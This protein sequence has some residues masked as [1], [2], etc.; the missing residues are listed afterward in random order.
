LPDAQC[1]AARFRFLPFSPAAFQG[2]E[3][4]TEAALAAVSYDD[5]APMAGGVGR[6]ETD[7]ADPGSLRLLTELRLKL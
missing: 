4:Q 7:T 2:G 1:S 5:A 3:H 6:R